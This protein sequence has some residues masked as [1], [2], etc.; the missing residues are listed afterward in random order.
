MSTVAVVPAYNNSETVGD[1]VRALAQDPRV[2]EVIV[3]DDGSTD[4]TAAQAAAAGAKVIRL[5]KNSGKHAA[6]ERGMS[7]AADADVFLLVDA[8]TGET[9][10]EVVTLIDPVLRAEADMAVGIL[11]SAGSAGGFGTVRHTAAWLIRVTSGFKATAPLSGQRALSRRVF[12]SCRPFARG[13]GVDAALTADAV[14]RGFRV[15]E[16][17]V[18]MTHRHRGRT[19]GGF[20]HRARQGW[21]L[22]IAF[23]PRLTFRRGPR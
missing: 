2:D 8:D 12:E 19:L 14:R 23:A 1:T 21:H 5:P 11:P 6:L 13:F 4:A 9:A 16:I 7:D 17:P 18:T 10:S 3:V 22:L 15:V 20:R